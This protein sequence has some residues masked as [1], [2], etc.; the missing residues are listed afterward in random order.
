MV[1][2][3]FGSLNSFSFDGIPCWHQCYSEYLLQYRW[4]N[5]EPW[6]LCPGHQTTYFISKSVKKEEAVGAPI[7][8]ELTYET[9][10]LIKKKKKKPL[11]LPLWNQSESACF[12]IREISWHAETDP[13]VPEEISNPNSP[14]PP[15][16]PL[17][18]L[19]T[20]KNSGSI[21]WRI[22]ASSGIMVLGQRERKRYFT[23]FHILIEGDRIYFTLEVKGKRDQIYLR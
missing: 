22:P 7:A 2:M 19:L 4:G 16:P 14:P 11:M 15:P 6:I 17:L 21:K 3:R 1:F 9:S 20:P 5:R 12:H 23:Q 10:L 13:F 8:V 18:Q